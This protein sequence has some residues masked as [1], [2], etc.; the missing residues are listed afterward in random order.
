MNKVKTIVLKVDN[1]LLDKMVKY[2]TPKKRMKTPQYSI[3]QADEADSVVTI[4]ESGKVMFQGISADVDANMWKDLMKKEETKVKKEVIKTGEL[5][6]VCGSD[7]VVRNSKYGEFVGCSNYPKCDYIKGKKSK[8]KT[9]ITIDNTDYYNITSIGSDEVGTGDFFG[10]IVVCA[11]YVKKEDIKFLEDLKVKDSKKM[12]DEKILNIVPKIMEKIDYEVVVFD[13]KK[14]NELTK[15]GINMNAI[16]AIMHNMAFTKLVERHDNYN[17]V[18]LDQFCS[19]K[20]YFSYLKDQDNVF[21]N[22]NFMTKAEDKNM[23]VACGALISRYTFLTHLDKMGE[24]YDTFFPKGASNLVD[25][26]GRDF[27]KRYGFDE[28]E[29]VAKINFKNVEKIKNMLN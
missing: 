24:K 23:A 21:K 13:N 10:P 29:K 25:E 12:M 6:P 14:F 15:K 20:N 22:I 7:L 16:K 3:L 19:S 8:E 2:Y 26:F 11:T 17:H 1:E 27:V 5:C 18:V 4:Y 28:L 9:K